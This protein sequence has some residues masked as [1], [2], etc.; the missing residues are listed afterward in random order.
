MLKKIQQGFTLIELMIVV[1]IIGILAAIALPQ[2]QDYTIRTQISEG[3]VLAGAAKLAVA[4]TYSSTSAP[5]I[6]EYTGAGVPAAN[7]Y[8]YQFQP[9]DKVATIKI[10]KWT[11]TADP[12]DGDGAITIT[13]TTKLATALGTPITLTPGSGDPS[14]ASTKFAAVEP[15]LPITWR[16]AVAAK[17]DAYRFVPSTCRQ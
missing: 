12:A 4:E 6:D 15:G 16:C 8:G 14:P 1:A 11:N 5:S 2:Y 17:T 13:Y 7:S 9:T 3:L 10:A